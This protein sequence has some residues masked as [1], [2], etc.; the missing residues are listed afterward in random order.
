MTAVAPGAL[1]VDAS[2]AIKWHVA[3]VHSAAALRLL[4]DDA[5][6]LHVPDLLFLEV[7]NILWKKV[8]RGDLSGDHAR[9]IAR[10]IATAP[11]EIHPS[12]PLFEAAV[13]IAIQTGRTVYDS[14][15]VALAVSLAGRLVTADEHLVNALKT[16]PLAGH[17]LWV[18]DPF[19]PDRPQA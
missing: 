8:R 7:G 18:G 11:V 14:L 17:V 13:E 4:A 19:T 3:E 1:V 6:R 16:S 9:Q 5:P 10:L 15:Y 2:V 12:L